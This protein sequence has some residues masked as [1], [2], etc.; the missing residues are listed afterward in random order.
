MQMWFARAAGMVLVAT[1]AVACGGGNDSPTAPSTPT[2]IIGVS[3][4]LAFGDVPVGGQRD[5]TFTITNTGTSTLNVTGMS[6]SGGLSSHTTASWTNGSIAAGA[7]QVVTV[8]FA[9]TASGSFNGTLSVNGDHTSGANTLPIS[10]TATGASATGTWLGRYIVERCDGTGSVQDIFCSTTRGVYPPGTS[11]PITI[12]LTQSGSS[13]S[14]TLALGQVTGSVSGD[15]TS[16]GVLTLRGTVSS[17]TISATIASW[18]TVI[19]NNQMDGSIGYNFTERNTPGVA[20][21]HSRLSDVTR[22]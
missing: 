5:Q 9:P 18:N 6:V 11:L 14:G 8:R 3:G 22:R 20:A 1:M 12:A 15:I 7:S 4:N 16:G 17:G 21:V 13:V 2:R 19:V 10:G